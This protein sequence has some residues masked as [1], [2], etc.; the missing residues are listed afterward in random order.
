MRVVLLLW[1]LMIWMPALRSE[2]QTC[3]R[4]SMQLLEAHVARGRAVPG[5]AVTNFPRGDSSM[6]FLKPQVDKNP[7][8]GFGNAVS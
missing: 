4:C 5:Y 7:Q 8:E 6:V 3:S 2:C 1:S